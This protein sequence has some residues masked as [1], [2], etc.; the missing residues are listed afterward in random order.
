MRIG[1]NRF[2]SPGKVIQF[3][4]NP[5]S[6]VLTD[7]TFTM[8]PADDNSEPDNIINNIGT[9]SGDALTM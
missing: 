1:K 6:L 7:Q 8:N 4:L 5:H 2:G 3:R 9:L